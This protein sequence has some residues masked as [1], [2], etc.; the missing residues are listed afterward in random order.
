MADVYCIVSRTVKLSQPTPKISLQQPLAYDNA[1]A[2][3]M[4]VSVVDDD[5]NP[6]DLTDIGVVAS[7]LRADGNPVT[8]IIGSVITQT[9]GTVKNIAQVI[10]PPS[11]YTIPGRFKFT[12]NLSDL[13]GA[14]RT[15]LWVEG[16]VEQNATGEAVDPG[17]PVSNIEQVIAR[18]ESAALAAQGVANFA[19]RYDTAQTLTEE[20]IAQV[21]ANI[22]IAGIATPAETKTYLEF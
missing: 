22:G 17:T 18:A 13:S 20:Q 9:G 3:A 4:Q 5:G 15:I 10:L 7:F 16:V 14:V 11:C 1:Y 19:V 21:Y 6:V 12:L 2:H 8:P